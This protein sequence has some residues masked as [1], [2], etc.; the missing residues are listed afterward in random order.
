MMLGDRKRSGTP[1]E[2]EDF[3][4]SQAMTSASNVTRFSEAGRGHRGG[5]GTAERADNG[6]QGQAGSGL[7]T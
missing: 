3:T 5:E 7:R 6:G 2:T 1:T 4:E